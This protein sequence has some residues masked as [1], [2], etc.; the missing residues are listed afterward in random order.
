MGLTVGVDHEVG[1]PS[2]RAQGPHEITEE[3]R[4]Q[5][6]VR[7]VDQHRDVLLA[8]PGPVPVA[9]A[10]HHGIPVVPEVA[11]E[12]QLTGER[13]VQTAP[14]VQLL[15][16]Q[17]Q[18]DPTPGPQ[19]GLGRGDP[20]VGGG[21][22]G[23]GDPGRSAFGEGGKEAAHGACSHPARPGRLRTTSAAWGSGPFPVR[24]RDQRRRC[25]NSSTLHRIRSAGPRAPTGRG[26]RLWPARSSRSPRAR[27]SRAE[28]GG[29]AGVSAGALRRSSVGAGA[30]EDGRRR[31]PTPGPASR[32]RPAR[33]GR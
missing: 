14:L 6:R 16:V 12:P 10:V 22:E 27:A 13:P 7:T 20:G 9:E 24:S 3:L 11:R 28:V 29:Y 5:Q 21:G 17:A 32:R 25:G 19:L 26:G 18:D 15:T 1:P 31:K 23:E 33:S 30:D 4:A 8:V 2:A